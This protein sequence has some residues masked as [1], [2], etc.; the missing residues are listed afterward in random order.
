MIRG[1][2]L[3]D[4]VNTELGL[5]T[6]GVVKSKH[7]EKTYLCPLCDRDVDVGE[8]HIIIVPVYFP[9]LRRHAHGECL[10]IFIEQKLTVK[11]HPNEPN[12]VMFHI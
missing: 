6:I 4:S 2:K 8:V 1:F 10:E 12:A 7:A 9:S 5:A 3:P 11:L